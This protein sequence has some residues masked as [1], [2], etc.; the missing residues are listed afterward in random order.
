MNIQILM[1]IMVHMISQTALL[2]IN[3]LILNMGG[4]N[5]NLNIVTV[6]L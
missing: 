6:F 1:S 4:I 5:Y 2:K 3:N